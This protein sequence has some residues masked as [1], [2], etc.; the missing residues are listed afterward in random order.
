MN[1]RYV[2][3]LLFKLKLFL[4]RAARSAKR[5]SADNGESRYLD[6]LFFNL[7]QMDSNEQ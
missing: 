5:R 6:L 3:F 4:A 1:L 7:L 2:L